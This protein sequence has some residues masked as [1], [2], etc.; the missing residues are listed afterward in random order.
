MKTQG[1]FIQTCL[2]SQPPPQPSGTGGAAVA[3]AV[4]A[5]VAEEG[6]DEGAGKRGEVG[7]HR[8]FIHFRPVPHNCTVMIGQFNCL[9]FFVLTL[10]IF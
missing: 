5:A 1:W 8:A 3:T 7:Q 10:S 9:L 2:G 6:P 4:A